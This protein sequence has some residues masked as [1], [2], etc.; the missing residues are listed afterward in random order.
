MNLAIEREKEIRKEFLRERTAIEVGKPLPG[1]KV[2]KPLPGTI[3]K[4][5]IYEF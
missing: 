3:W 5:E 2:G 1:G 4:S